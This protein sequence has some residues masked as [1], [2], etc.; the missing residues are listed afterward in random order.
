[1]RYFFF[2]SSRRRHTRYWRDWS[3]DVCSSDLEYLGQRGLIFRDR[4]PPVSG[5]FE[6]EGSRPRVDRSP[7]WD[8]WHSVRV[9]AGEAQTLLGEGVEVWGLYPGVAVGP[10]V[11]LSQAVQN[12]QDDVAAGRPARRKV[13]FGKL[14]GV[15]APGGAEQGG[16]SHTGGPQEVFAR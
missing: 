9:R 12:D 11:V 10:D 5:R 3:S 8:G 15:V 1:M 2:F 6:G 14:G 4:S 13:V 16:S 7:G